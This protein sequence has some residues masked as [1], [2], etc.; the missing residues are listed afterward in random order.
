MITKS[1]LFDDALGRQMKAQA[2][3]DLLE[4]S[5]ST[6]YRDPTKYGGVKIGGRWRFY[7]RYIVE[8]INQRR[9]EQNARQTENQRLSVLLRQGDS[10]GR[11]GA[12]EEIQQEGRSVRLGAGAEAVPVDSYSS[13]HQ[14]W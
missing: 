5:L 3:A 9:V 7:E 14:L 4:L 8:T 1:C 13:R 12:G 10:A 11:Q 2:V 6:I